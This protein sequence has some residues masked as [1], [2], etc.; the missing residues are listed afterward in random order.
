MQCRHIHIS[1]FGTSLK[2]VALNTPSIIYKK[3]NLHVSYLV[4]EKYDR[5][6]KIFKSI[7]SVISNMQWQHW[8]VA[9]G[10]SPP[11]PTSKALPP[12]HFLCKCSCFLTGFSAQTFR[13]QQQFDLLFSRWLNNHNKPLS[14]TILQIQIYIDRFHT[15]ILTF[16][17]MIGKKLH[18][19]TN[20][21][22]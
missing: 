15:P 9:W 13:Q 4:C 7:A 1:S 14:V 11:P 12:T 8:G 20:N 22:Y 21:N 5:H 10:H 19:A 2:F 18:H 17:I 6:I 3:V 16:I